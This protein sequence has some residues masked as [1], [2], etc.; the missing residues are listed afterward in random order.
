MIG[1]I[2]FRLNANDLS[3]GGRG[4]VI[5]GVLGFAPGSAD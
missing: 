5:E 4:A 3:R 2:G 1:S